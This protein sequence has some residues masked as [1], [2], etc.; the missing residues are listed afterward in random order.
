MAGAGDFP[1]LNLV[2]GVSG[3]CVDDGWFDP[4]QTEEAQGQGEAG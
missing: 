3:V 4:S 2:F 1:S